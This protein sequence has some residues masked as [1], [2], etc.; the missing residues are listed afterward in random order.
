MLSGKLTRKTRVPFGPLLILG[1]V[2]AA[3]WGTSILA[4]YF[5]IYF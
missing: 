2:V 1:A 3:W 5:S 4:W